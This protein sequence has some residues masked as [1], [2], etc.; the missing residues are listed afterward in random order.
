[1]ITPDKNRTRQLRLIPAAFSIQALIPNYIRQILMSFMELSAYLTRD[2]Q[3][4]G[5]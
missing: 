2:I 3:L 1:M 5:E 4:G